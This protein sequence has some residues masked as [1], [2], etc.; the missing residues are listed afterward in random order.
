MQYKKVHLA[1]KEPLLCIWDWRQWRGETQKKELN[2]VATTQDC[3]LQITFNLRTRR[4][5]KLKF[6]VNLLPIVNPQLLCVHI[7]MRCLEWDDKIYILHSGALFI[8]IQ[9]QFYSLFYADSS[10]IKKHELA[11]VLEKIK[12]EEKWK[13]QEKL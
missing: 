9:M 6:Y 5:R 11:V 10:S 3:T 7:C 1:D 8:I 13:T 2:I 12:S 4:R